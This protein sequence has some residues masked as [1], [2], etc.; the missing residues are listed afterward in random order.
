MKRRAFISLLGGAAAWPL[1]ASAQQAG[2][3]PTIGFFSPNSRSAANPWTAAFV[4]RLREL[5]WSDKQTIAIVYRYSEGEPE[6]VA[7]FVAEF[8]RLKVDVI[9]T[10]GEP[11]IVAA[12]QATSVIPIVFA[13]AA[14]PIG[15]GLV[16]SLPKPGGNITGLSLQMPDL[17]GKRLELL[18]EAV[19]SLRRLA[20]LANLG[21]SPNVLEMGEVQA[22]TRALGLDTVVLDVRR[23]EEIAPAFETLKAS[24]DGLY[25]CAS[26]LVNTNRVRINT[27][28]LTAR[29]PSV[30]SFRE[31]VDAGA[32]MSY[33]PNFSD[34]FRRA[35]EYVDKILRGAKPGDIPVEQPTKFDFVVNLTT[36][37][38]LGLTIPD[39]LLSIADEVIE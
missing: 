22:A 28:A 33:G 21:H 23:A 31:P 13:V 7:D 37:R 8:V 38:A 29:L 30:H 25:I 36:A 5:G 3:L 18:R 11:N 10:H 34:L 24:A 9:V 17:G 14:D 2:T 39:K 20:I 12:K 15:T 26:P 32:L 16:A 1:A 27:W 4:Q 35:A 19:P 6:R